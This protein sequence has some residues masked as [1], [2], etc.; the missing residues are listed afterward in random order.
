MFLFLRKLKK[1]NEDVV[2][3]DYK[4]KKKK[5]YI[6]IYIY[7]YIYNAVLKTAEK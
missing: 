6:Y 1:L 3:T 5:K 7:I 2:V 4:K